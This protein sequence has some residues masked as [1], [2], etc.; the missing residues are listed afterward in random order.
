MLYSH[1]DDIEEELGI[2]LEWDR[3][4]TY[5]ASWMCYALNG[6]SITNEADWPRMAKFHAEWSDKICGAMLSYLQ[7][8]NSMRLQNIAGVFREWAMSRPDVDLNM[9]KCNR[10]YTRFT[11]PGMTAILPDLLDVPSGWNTDN[12]Y[13]YEIINRNG[14]EAY[15]QFAISSKNIT[16]EFG[17]IC[18]KINAFYP[19]KMGKEEWLWRTPFRTSNISIPEDLSQDTISTSLDSCLDEILAFEADLAEK[20]KV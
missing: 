1:K 3:A 14:K 9:E 5:K 4:D 20:V 13:F 6:V 8:G 2:T 15:I 17:T 16:D 11:T 7:D 10:T 18:D 19:A 12:H